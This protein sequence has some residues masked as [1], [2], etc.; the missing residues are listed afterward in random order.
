[1][2]GVK[3]SPALKWFVL[4]LLPITLGLK[5]AVRAGVDSG[6][7]SDKQVQVKVADFLLRQHFNVVKIEK[8][9]EG[10]PMLRA[11]AAE[12]R[13]LVAKSPV[14]GSDRDVLQQ[15]VTGAD[16]LFV[17]YRGK[18]YAD[19]P[20]WLTVSDLLWA[21]FRRGLGLSAEAAPPV[22]AVIAGP[23]CGAEQLPWDELS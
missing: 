19:P 23:A 3:S 16:R 7:G 21:R 2:Y 14:I 4:V 13:M 15:L 12:C 22:L 1:M 10:Q 6:E 5:L 20:T 18:V 17:V 9:E 11:T 8:F